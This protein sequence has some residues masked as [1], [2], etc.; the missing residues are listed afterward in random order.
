MTPPL[1]LTLA[2]DSASQG[3]FDRERQRWFPPALNMIPAHV[4]LFHHLPGDELPRIQDDL[5]R[6]CADQAASAFTMDGLR[7]LGRGTA[8]SLHAPEIADFR[9][10]CA[11]LWQAGLT[12]QDRQGW[13]PHVTVQ[14]KA[15]PK[16]ARA[17]HA[18]LTRDFMP[19]TGT[20]TGVTLWHY[21]GG[22]WEHA[23]SFTFGGPT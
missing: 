8:Y 4:T 6:L 13:R 1:I 7:F 2:L 22:P 20:A 16:A 9:G 3:F 5:A 23:A 12:A 14:N 10:R 17:L 18:Q 11:A 15:D 19:M 21:L